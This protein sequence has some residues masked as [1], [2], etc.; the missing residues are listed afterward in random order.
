MENLWDKICAEHAEVDI[1]DFSDQP[2]RMQRKDVI[3]DY[4]KC[5][6]GKLIFCGFSFY[7]SATYYDN[8]LMPII[9]SG[10][11]E[12]IKTAESENVFK[13]KKRNKFN[14]CDFLTEYLFNANPKRAGKHEH[15]EL[16]EIPFCQ[17]FDKDFPR[18]PLPLS[19]RY[20]TI[21]SSKCNCGHLDLPM[22]K[23]Q[24]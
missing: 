21:Y 4:K 3:I 1:D 16:G 12:M 8:V 5:S 9:A 18:K 11:T 14:G 24:Q 22:I 7:L 20:K 17:E 23:R 19:V 15:T 13:Y 10:L 2:K 6:A